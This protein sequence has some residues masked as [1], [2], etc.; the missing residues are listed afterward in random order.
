M[1]S[2]TKYRIANARPRFRSVYGF[3]STITRVAGSFKS[4]IDI[5][6]VIDK[7]VINLLDLQE[8]FKFHE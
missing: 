2:F 3:M 1:R 5:R 6:T 8:S 7:K 4:T